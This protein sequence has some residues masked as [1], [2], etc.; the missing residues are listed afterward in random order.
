MTCPTTHRTPRT[1]AE[2]RFTTGYPMARRAPSR[3]A[4][5]L[6]AIA[7]GAG[8]ALVIVYGGRP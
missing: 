7:I 4:A 6:L 2:C 3:V 5:W 8:L 1:L